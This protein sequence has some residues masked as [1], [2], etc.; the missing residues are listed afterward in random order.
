MISEGIVLTLNLQRNQYYIVTDIRTQIETAIY[1]KRESSLKM[2]MTLFAK[3][4]D[5]FLDT[6]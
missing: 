2:G 1:F 3:V 6:H 5:Q 4:H